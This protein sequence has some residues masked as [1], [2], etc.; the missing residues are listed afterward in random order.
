MPS[1]YEGAVRFSGTW[2]GAPIQ[3][4]GAM[5]LVKGTDMSKSMEQTLE[6]ATS[7]VRQELEAWIPASI[8]PGHFEQI[9]RVHFDP[10]E[11]DKIQQSIVNGFYMLNDRGGKNW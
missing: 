3:G 8:R 5:E 9:T 2:Q 6:N 1:F 11:E 4:Y 10:Y 7:V